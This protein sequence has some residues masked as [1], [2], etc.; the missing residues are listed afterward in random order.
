M[1]RHLGFFRLCHEQALSQNPL[2]SGRVTLHF[3]VTRE[4]Q[5]RDARADG[6]YPI[7]TG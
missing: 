4:G 6:D 1:L 7:P 3:T 5:V 2:A